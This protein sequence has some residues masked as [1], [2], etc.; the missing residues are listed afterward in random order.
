ML[1]GAP[2]VWC[3]DKYTAKYCADDLKGAAKTTVGRWNSRDN[4]VVYAPTS[5]VLATPETLA[6]LGNNIAIR[7]LD[8]L[9]TIK[10]DSN[11]IIIIGP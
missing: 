9:F 3:I 6:H 7:N 11:R 1:R 5:I 4:A 10:I 2:Q 8:S